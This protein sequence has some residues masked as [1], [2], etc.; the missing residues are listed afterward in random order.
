MS[1]NFGVLVPGPFI[2]KELDSVTLTLTHLRWQVSMPDPHEPMYDVHAARRVM[3]F[4]VYYRHRHSVNR[5]CSGDAA[6]RPLQVSVTGL[7][8]HFGLNPIV[9]RTLRAFVT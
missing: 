8:T 2:V 6:A 1:C 9:R 4:D 5:Q 7:T 3:G